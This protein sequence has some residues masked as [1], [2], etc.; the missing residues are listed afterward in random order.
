MQ[1]RMQLRRLLR[2]PIIGGYIPISRCP[3][4][5]A[6]VSVDTYGEKMKCGNCGSQRGGASVWE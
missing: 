6:R 5:G 4:C 1:E 3:S 2:M